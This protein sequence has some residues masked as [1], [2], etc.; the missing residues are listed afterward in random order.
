[1]ARGKPRPQPPRLPLRDAPK[2]QPPPDA[3]V[4]ADRDADGTVAVVLDGGAGEKPR[5]RPS[6]DDAVVA[7]VVATRMLLDGKRLP[8]PASCRWR[9]SL[10]WLLLLS[11]EP[12]VNYQENANL[13]CQTQ[14]C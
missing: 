13:L 6:A 8:F 3:A 10:W 4:V 7:A 5:G 11:L 1:M 2:L 12:A 9:Q 14:D